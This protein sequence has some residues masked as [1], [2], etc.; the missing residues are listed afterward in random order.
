M[1]IM[2]VY[3][4]ITKA[5]PIDEKVKRFYFF[6][7]NVFFPISINLKDSD[8]L[9]VFFPGAFDRSKD[10][11]KFQ[12][13][14]Y[15]DHLPYSCISLFD[16]TLFLGENIG[17]GWFQGDKSQFYAELLSEVIEK[18]KN[19]LKIEN[20]NILFF[21]TS[22]GGIPAIHAS[23]CLPEISIY[24]GNIQT[25]LS[26]HN[27]L[28][29]SLFLKGILGVD[30][31]EI[32]KELYVDRYNINNCNNN[33]NLYYAQNKSDIF[34]YKNHY[35]NYMEILK[36]LDNIIVENVIYKHDASGHNP[37]SM[38]ME[39]KIIHSIFLEKTIV[40]TLSPYMI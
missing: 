12:R 40:K 31:F 30:N 26:V 16:P 1:I 8:K 4:S 3:S 7:K 36:S 14:S 27:K 5:L 15:F 33:I 24:C 23:K 20:S 32:F 28:S 18:I 17:S 9:V 21:G 19:Y 25:D 11:P 37:I 10:I 29:R 38:G 2:N 39:I 34:H 13:E 6:Y 22:A 35:L